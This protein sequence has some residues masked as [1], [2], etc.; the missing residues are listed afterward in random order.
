M[1]A[2]LAFGLSACAGASTSNTVAPSRVVQTAAPQE[3]SKAFRFGVPV[4]NEAHALIAAEAGL[5]SSFNYTQPLT[6]VSVERTNYGDYSRRTHAGSDRPADMQVWLVIYHDNEF[7][8]IPSRPDVTPSPPFR[9]C[10]AVLINAA[11]GLPLETSGPL[12]KGEFPAC[13]K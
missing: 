6:V 12:E 9:G 5:R 7:Q 2:F 11:D 10:A 3:S 13:D 4:E 8:S 1:M